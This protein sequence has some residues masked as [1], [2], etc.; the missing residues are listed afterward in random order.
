MPVNLKKSF[1]IGLVVVLFL[2]IGFY[3][4]SRSAA[5]RGGVT[6]IVNG[7][8]DGET[9]TDGTLHLS[10]TAQNAT[11]LSLDDRPISVS[12]EGAFAEQLLLL[13]GYNIIT[14]KAEDRFGQKTQKVFRVI[15]TPISIIN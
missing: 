10:G 6:L 2:I 14:F 12:Q 4:Y 13:P 7:V 3:A 9:V 8:T 11:V 5:V 15:Y 1:G